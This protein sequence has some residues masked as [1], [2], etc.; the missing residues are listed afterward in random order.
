M[1]KKPAAE[2]F[3]FVN[4]SLEPEHKRAIFCYKI[5]FS[6]RPTLS[7]SETIVFPEELLLGRIP[8]ELLENALQGVH[9]MLGI[10]YYKLYCPSKIIL[11]TR[12]IS[13]EQ[14]DFWNIIYRKGLGEFLFRNEIDPNI[15]IE[16]PYDRKVTIGPS[17]IRNRD[18]SLVGIGGGKDSIVVGELL[19]GHGDDFS[20]LL[21]ETQV[22]SPVSDAVVKLMGVPSVVIRRF[23][24]PKIFEPHD[25]SYNGHIPISAVFAFVGYLTAILY[26]FSHIVVGNEHSS[27]FGNVQLDNVEINHQWSK[28]SE[29]ER[30]FRGYAEQFLSSGVVYF[31]LLRPFHEIRIAEM[32]AG[33][34]KYFHVFSSCNRNVRIHKERPKTLWCGECP[35][36][37]FV[38]AML[39]PFLKKETLVGIFGRNLFEDEALVPMFAD[40]LGFGSM[41]PF[42]CVGT[43]DEAQ[44]AFFL[45]REKYADTVV[46][47]Q[48]VGRIENPECLIGETFS[49]TSAPTLPARF[50]LYGMKNVLIL[51]Y[52]KEGKTTEQYLKKYFPEIQIAIG[53]RSADPDYLK[54]QDQYDLVIKT[55]GVPRALVTVP[56]TTATN[57]FFSSVHNTVIGVTGSKGKSTTASLIYSILKEAGKKVRLLG[58]IGTPLLS[59]L[60]E[61]IDQD[62]IFV[63]EL[64]SYQLDDVKYSPDVA[65]VLNLFPEHMNYHG[66]VE[67]YY[68]A[69][70]NIM[71]FQ[72]HCDTFIYDAKDRRMSAWAKDSVARRVSYTDGH[73]PQGI[74][75]ALQGEHNMQ[76]ITAAIAAVG[77]FHISD[78]VIRAAIAMFVPLRHRLENVGEFRGI[79]FYDDANAT[80]PE[81]VVMALQAIPNVDTIFLGGEDRGYDFSILEKRI[82]KSG[83]RNIVLF[84]ESGKRMLRS[85]DGFTVFETSNMEEAVAFAYEHTSKGSVCLLSMASPSYTLWKNFEEKGDQFRYWVEKMA[86]E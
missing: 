61:P 65:V 66:N 53:D 28:S 78:D 38:F 67:K 23:L 33:H 70:R 58:N 74:M 17:T 77:P 63:V 24:D 59:V 76:N 34:P 37:L 14:A 55:P 2:K 56:Y 52:G 60:L 7:F 64:S 27:D 75:T 26:D 25:G 32:F 72:H 21:I 9:L 6:D 84:P 42:D 8:T 47:K 19:K 18:R 16:F 83:V 44:A 73:I 50:A 51:G 80:T 5:T 11:E 35:K 31:S 36:C 54:R 45:A 20:A 13:R 30:L 12:S 29:F 39:S 10:S 1:K 81:A 68:D 41:K 86:K 43:F 3:I 15:K 4:Y 69:K 48:F 57:I 40:I 71:Q 46:M 85:R 62:E 79:T 22:G 82:R 49:T